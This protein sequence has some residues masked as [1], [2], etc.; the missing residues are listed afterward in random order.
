MVPSA[1][2]MISEISLAME[3]GFSFDKLAKVMHVYPSYS[4][5][6]Q[7]MVAEVYYERTLRLKPVYDS[8]KSIEL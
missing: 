8:L 1:G 5:A 2:Q 7:Q 3:A 4:I 6:L